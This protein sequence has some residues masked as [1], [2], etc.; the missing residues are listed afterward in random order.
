LSPGSGSGI[1]LAVSGRGGAI[2][3]L[4][5]SEGRLG[6][7]FKWPRAAGAVAFA[8]ACAILIAGS[9]DAMARPAHKHARHG[10]SAK[11]EHHH[12]KTKAVERAV[13]PRILPS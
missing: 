4:R 1:V 9:A 12:K 2:S 8:A 13:G 7:P 6:R 10:K 3:N 5:L 11:S